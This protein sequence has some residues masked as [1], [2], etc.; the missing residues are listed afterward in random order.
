MGF[1]SLTPAAGRGGDQIG[2]DLR[3]SR[4]FPARD[5]CYRRSAPVLEVAL[6]PRRQ[7]RCPRR[8]RAGESQTHPEEPVPGSRPNRRT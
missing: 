3:V 2:P 4:V 8:R 5:F 7:G 1:P 6:Y